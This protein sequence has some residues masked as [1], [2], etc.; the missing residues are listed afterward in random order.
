MMYVNYIKRKRKSKGSYYF[1][2]YIRL[3]VSAIVR[4]KS[5]EKLKRITENCICK[6]CKSQPLMGRFDHVFRGCHFRCKGN[7]C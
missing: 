4:S 7:I 6:R 3:S 1:N 5:N 2:Q